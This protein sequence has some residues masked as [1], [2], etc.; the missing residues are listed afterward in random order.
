MN[1]PR[2][3][4]LAAA[5]LALALATPAW[6][7]YEPP[8]FRAGGGPILPAGA[9]SDRFET[10]WQLTGGIGWKLVHETLAMRFDYD[11]SRERLVGGALSAGFVNGEHQIHSLEA[12][13]EWTLTPGGPAPVHLF[14]GPGVYLQQTAITNLR[15]YA[16]GPPICDPWLQVCLPGP[17][18]PEEIL[19][20]RSSTDLGF[21]LGAGVDIPIRG[22]VAAFVEVRWRFVWGNAYGLP[23]GSEHRATSN[24][25]PLTLGVRF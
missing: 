15:D 7:Q 2:A 23:G 19:G 10:G 8:R 17:V 1:P 4:S 20:S 12:D 16:P 14:A 11:Y 5:A 25:F 13:L 3:T 6:A 21:N 22:R 24:Y 18:P 9:I